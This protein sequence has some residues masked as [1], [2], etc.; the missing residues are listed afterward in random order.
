VPRQLA[1]QLRGERTAP[2]AIPEA[3]ILDVEEKGPRSRSL[4]EDFPVPS[5]GVQDVE[6]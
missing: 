4:C 5:M 3:V 6:G 1:F 2:G